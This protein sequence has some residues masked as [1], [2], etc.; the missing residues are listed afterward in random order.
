MDKHVC[1]THNYNEEIN[2]VTGQ[3]QTLKNTKSETEET[4][5]HH[6]S[7]SHNSSFDSSSDLKGLSQTD[8]IIEVTISNMIYVANFPVSINQNRTISLY[9]YDTGAT[10]SCMSKSCFDKLQPQPKLVKM[11]TNKVNDAD[12]NSLGP[13]GMTTCTLKFSKN[14]TNN[15]FS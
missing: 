8:E 6:D 13:I 4:K 12:G 7:D 2:E 11:N 3:T 15:S 5:D 10:I 9:D 14:S 1:K